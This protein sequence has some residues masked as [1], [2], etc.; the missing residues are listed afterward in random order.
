MTSNGK[1][2]YVIL[3]AA[4]YQ[5]IANPPFSGLPNPGPFPFQ[6]PPGGGEVAPRPIWPGSCPQRPPRPITDPVTGLINC[7]EWLQDG[8]QHGGGLNKVYCVLM[9]WLCVGSV[10]AG[11][12]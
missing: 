3:D 11:G 10:H 6:P 2:E 4:T 1:S 9:Y 8:L 7:P 12:A 5:A